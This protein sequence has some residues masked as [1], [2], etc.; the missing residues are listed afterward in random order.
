MN[1]ELVAQT[2]E[3]LAAGLLDNRKSVDA[4]RIRRL[5]EKAYGRPATAEETAKAQDFLRACERELRDR[6]PDAGKRRTRAWACLCQVIVAANE[7][8]NVR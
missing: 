2:S 8:I 5:Y 7:F 4:G 1:S 6:E 3:R